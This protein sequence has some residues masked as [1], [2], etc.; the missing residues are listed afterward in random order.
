MRGLGFRLILG[1][2]FS[3]GAHLYQNA[4]MFPDTTPYVHTTPLCSFSS[5]KSKASG[6]ELLVPYWD[7]KVTHQLYMYICISYIYIYMYIYIYIYTMCIYIYI[8]IYICNV[9]YIHIERERERVAF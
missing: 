4:C 2:G 6:L 1:L 5:T 3:E 9:T 8:Y 7:S